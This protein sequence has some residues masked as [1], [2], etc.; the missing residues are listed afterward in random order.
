MNASATGELLSDARVRHGFS[1]E[2]LAIRAGVSR[3]KIADIESGRAS[4]RVDALSELLELLGE[5]L[6]LHTKHRITG[7]DLTLNRG[8]L[9]ISPDHRVQKGLAFAGLVR[10]LQSDGAAALGRSFNLDPSW[11]Y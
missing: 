3:A 7:I 5:K 11:A 1:Q 10:E 8:N 4:L 6:V 2:A 9:Q